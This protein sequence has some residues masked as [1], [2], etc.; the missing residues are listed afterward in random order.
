[1]T[2]SDYIRIGA[3]TRAKELLEEIRKQAEELYRRSFLP[4][5]AAVQELKID[6]DELIEALDTYD[7]A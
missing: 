3:R 6:V 4:T 7:K 5:Q 2:E 1:M